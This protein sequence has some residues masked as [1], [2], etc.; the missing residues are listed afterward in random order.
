MRSTVGNRDKRKLPTPP[1]AEVGVF[2][3][4]RSVSCSFPFFP[5]SSFFPVA[6][7]SFPF[8]Y[9]DSPHLI[10]NNNGILET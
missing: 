6:F 4:F 2:V 8:I 1:I 7:I 5:T 10:H 9:S 3:L